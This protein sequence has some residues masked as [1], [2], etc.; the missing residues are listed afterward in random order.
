MD[1]APSDN[2]PM[3]IFTAWTMLVLHNRLSATTTLLLGIGAVATGLPDILAFEPQMQLQILNGVL[4]LTA[5]LLCL[6]E[7]PVKLSWFESGVITE[8]FWLLFINSYKQVYHLV[9]YILKT[10]MKISFFFLLLFC[11]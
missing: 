4:I 7:V 5:V 8:I 2:S 1:R 6:Q 3:C 10:K 9:N 11:L